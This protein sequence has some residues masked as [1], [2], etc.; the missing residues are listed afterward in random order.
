MIGAVPTFVDIIPLIEFHPPAT[1][2]GSMEL[3][4]TLHFFCL[5]DLIIFVAVGREGIRKLQLALKCFYSEDV[6]LGAKE[7]WAYLY[8]LR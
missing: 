8:G 3:N 1:I 2:D 4:D 6:F 7:F 5:K